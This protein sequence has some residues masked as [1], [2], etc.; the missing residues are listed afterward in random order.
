MLCFILHIKYSQV[1]TTS[2]KDSNESKI[3]NQSKEEQ[4]LKKALNSAVL[5]ENGPSHITSVW[6]Y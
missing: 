4:I 6:N 3:K 2:N 5:G 1:S